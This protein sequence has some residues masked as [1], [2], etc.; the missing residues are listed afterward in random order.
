[1]VFEPPTARWGAG[2]LCSRLR[3]NLTRWFCPF[4]PVYL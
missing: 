2:G 3:A 1:M 4:S